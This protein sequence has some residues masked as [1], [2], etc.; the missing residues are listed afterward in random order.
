LDYKLKHLILVLTSAILAI[1]LPFYI[2]IGWE[3]PFIILL[4]CT[5]TK[6]LG[7]EIGSHRLWSHNSFTTSLI[8][9]RI[10]IVLN[11]FAG[12]GSILAFVGIHRAHHAY[13]DTDKDPH[14]PHTNMWNTIFYQHNTASFNSRSIKDIFRDRWLVAQH[15]HYF[16]F[17]VAIYVILA[18]ISMTA[19][20]YYAVNILYTLWINYLVNVACHRW[21]NK[22][23]DLPN[24][25]TNNLWVNRIFLLGAGLHNNH[26]ARPWEWN[27][28]WG[29]YK[30]DLWA[31]VIKLIKK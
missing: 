4:V 3:A 22:D 13:S 24:T 16:K 2:S 27:N 18:M 30:F 10:L 20:W 7:S 8:W 21:G 31:Q 12:E 14:N 1:V 6:G 15:K 19:V 26:H 29:N 23:N 9:Q 28:A 25:S 11:T 5:L 17:Q